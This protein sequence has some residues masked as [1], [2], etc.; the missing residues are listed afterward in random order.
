MANH[1]QYGTKTLSLRVST[2][3]YVG[4]IQAA[5]GKKLST[6]EYMTFKLF[7]P[8][9]NTPALEKE[10]EVLKS[11]L[12]AIQSEKTKADIHLKELDKKLQDGIKCINQA[13]AFIKSKGHKEW[14]IPAWELEAKKQ[15]E[16][17]K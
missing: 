1:S 5:E 2:Q 7:K 17:K 9:D 8:D 14:F 11:K 10:I 3:D 4:V 13:N 15:A 6:A 16:I 12:N